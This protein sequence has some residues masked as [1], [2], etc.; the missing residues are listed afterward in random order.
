MS[1]NEKLSQNDRQLW[2]IV[3][4]IHESVYPYLTYFYFEEILKKNDRN[5]FEKILSLA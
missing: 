5:F 1:D 4:K 2:L 3:N